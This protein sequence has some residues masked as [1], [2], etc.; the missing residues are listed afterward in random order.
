MLTRTSWCQNYNLFSDPGDITRPAAQYGIICVL[1]LFL[2]HGYLIF[3]FVETIKPA[4]FCMAKCTLQ[5]MIVMCFNDCGGNGACYW[6]IM[7]S[8]EDGLT[9]WRRH[10]PELERHFSVFGHQKLWHA[11]GNNI[12]PVTGAAHWT[13]R[14]LCSTVASNFFYRQKVLGLRRF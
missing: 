11:T 8:E 1:L 6:T 2:L 3:W 5:L 10:S 14:P 12:C 4:H 7:A 9:L 13:L